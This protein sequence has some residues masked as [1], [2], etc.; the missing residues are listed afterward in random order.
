MASPATNG[1][2]WA[3]GGIGAVSEAYAAAMATLNPSHVCKLCRTLWQ[4]QILNPMSE[5]RDGTHILTE[6]T[7]GS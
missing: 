5:A 6:T 7:S 3:R 2:F 4:C 1:S